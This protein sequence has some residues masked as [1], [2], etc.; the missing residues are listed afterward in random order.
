M[1]TEKLEF[2]MTVPNAS[3]F[4]SV[5]RLAISGI[6]SR[7]GFSIEEIED[8]KVAVSE[9]CT[10]VI[11][12]AYD[13]QDDPNQH[14]ILVNAIIYPK[15]LEIIIEDKGKGFDLA[16]IGT[17][18]QKKQSEEKLG[19]GLGLTFI[20]SLMDDSEVTSEIGKGTRIKMIKN[21]PQ[22]QPVTE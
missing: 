3:E 16:H 2:K 4:V 10:N 21:S 5:I 22:T 6:A 11:Q 14:P 8:I 7:M 18:E 1:T 19:L 20:K 15:Q 9:A 13:E 12:H 17:D